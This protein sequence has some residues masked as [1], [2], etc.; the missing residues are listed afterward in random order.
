MK[1]YIG[2]IFECY[3]MRY[4]SPKYTNYERA[5]KTELYLNI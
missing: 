1:T 5:Q 3:Q 4:S 2:T